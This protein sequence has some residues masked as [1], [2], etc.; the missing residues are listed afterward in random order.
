ML[1]EVEEGLETMALNSVLGKGGLFEAEA[2]DLLLEIVVLL[3]GVAQVDVVR[4]AVTEVIAETV[5]ELLER[6]DGGDGPVTDESDA[7]AV[8]G[9]RVDGAAHL[10]GETDGLGQ[11]DSNQNQNVLETC[12]ERF[13]ALEM[14]I[15][16]LTHGRRCRCGCGG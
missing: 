3:A 4:P 7:A 11:E 2:G 16:E 14:I 6:R 9:G 5:E 10:N 12:E 15:R 13:H 1:L 8:G